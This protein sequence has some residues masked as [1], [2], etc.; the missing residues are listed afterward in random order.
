M[1][2]RPE[3]DLLAKEFQRERS[4]RRTAQVLSAKRES[5]HKDLHQLIAHLTLLLPSA[6]LSQ[7]GNDSNYDLL[8]AAL[9]R[10]GDDA[11]AQLILQ[12]LQELGQH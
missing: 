11:F 6:Q 10:L 12:V 5:I 3:P 4:I 2:E 8:Q 9:D 7:K 1:P